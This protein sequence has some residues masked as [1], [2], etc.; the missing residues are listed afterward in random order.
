MATEKSVAFFEIKSEL[1]VVRFR[2][3]QQRFAGKQIFIHTMCGVL[4]RS[5]TC[6]RI[7]RDLGLN[8][9]METGQGMVR[10]PRRFSLNFQ[11]PL[12]WGDYQ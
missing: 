8:L 1:A 11:R 3:H 9:R 7:Y 5:E 12:K 2:E 10:W 6:Y 4:G